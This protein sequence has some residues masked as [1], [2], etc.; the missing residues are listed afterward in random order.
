M[1]NEIKHGNNDIEKIINTCFKAKKNERYEKFSNI[2]NLNFNTVL[3]AEKID[4]ASKYDINPEDYRIF[5]YPNNITDSDYRNVANTFIVKIEQF[6][7]E[8]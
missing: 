6:F 2:V 7:S 5:Y 3:A 8:E 1:A 4:L